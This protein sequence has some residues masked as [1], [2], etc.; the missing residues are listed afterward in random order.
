MRGR[1]L[2]TFD[3]IEVCWDIQGSICTDVPWLF[4][5]IFSFELKG[6][7]QFHCMWV[8]ELVS[9]ELKIASV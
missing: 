7:G 5:I 4:R 3:L 9:L 2:D 1:S 6:T 8:F